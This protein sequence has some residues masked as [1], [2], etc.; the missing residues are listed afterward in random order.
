M[1][2]AVFC[3]CIFSH[4]L[5]GTFFKSKSSEISYFINTSTSKAA[6]CI[7]S[8]TWTCWFWIRRIKGKSRCSCHK[9][10]PCPY[11][12]PTELCSLEKRFFSVHGAVQMPQR[13]SQTTV[14]NLFNYSNL[15]ENYKVC[16]QRG[17]ITILHSGSLFQQSHLSYNFWA[18]CASFLLWKTMIVAII[19]IILLAMS[20]TPGSSD[21]FDSWHGMFK[22]QKK[23]AYWLVDNNAAVAGFGILNFAGIATYERRN[24]SFFLASSLMITGPCQFGQ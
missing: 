14:G 7:Y 2:Y 21:L 15:T 4:L 12:S 5:S 8:F 1:R 3:H 13:R 20:W 16:Y 23:L 10:L 6:L 18:G 22:S 11:F 9:K 17:K 19:C 24:N